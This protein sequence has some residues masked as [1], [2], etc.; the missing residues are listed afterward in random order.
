MI[1]ILEAKMI[2]SSSGGL[3]KIAVLYYNDEGFMRCAVCYSE[4]DVFTS[5]FPSLIITKDKL[6]SLAKF[7]TQIGWVESVKYFPNQQEYDE[8]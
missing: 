3:D 6:I 2:F 5:L 7:S 4:D 1:Q 8:Y